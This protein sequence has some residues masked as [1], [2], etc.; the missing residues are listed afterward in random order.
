MSTKNVLFNALVLS[1]TNYVT[2]SN[3]D[4]KTKAI[5]KAFGRWFQTKREA[6][7][8]TQ[9]YLAEQVDMNV[10]T[11]SRIENG[12][13][14]KRATVIKLAKAIGLDENEALRQTIFAPTDI[15]PYPKEL[16]MDYDGF[17]DDDLKDIAAYI[18]FR[19]IRKESEKTATSKK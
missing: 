14:T 3:V 16:I 7:P 2:F 6:V 17:D 9:E 18:E 15:K 12:D 19:K 4:E 10:K 13:P 1:R 11:L 8:M 5:W